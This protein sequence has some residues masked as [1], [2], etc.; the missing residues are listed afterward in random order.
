MKIC[1]KTTK[2]HKKKLKLCNKLLKKEKKY[3]NI[4]INTAIFN[5]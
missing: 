1:T 4:F 2:K 3:G 5:L